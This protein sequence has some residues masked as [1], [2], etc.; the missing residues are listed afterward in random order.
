LGGK[1]QHG[2]EQWP[3]PVVV[4]RI[5]GA[6]AH[7]PVQ[8]DRGQSGQRRPGWRGVPL[9]PGLRGVFAFLAAAASDLIDEV[10]HGTPFASVSAIAIAPAPW[11]PSRRAMPPAIWPIPNWIIATAMGGDII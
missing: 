2:H 10:G 1:L 7:R 3:G 8:I 5:V 9:R 6:A 11:M 4:E